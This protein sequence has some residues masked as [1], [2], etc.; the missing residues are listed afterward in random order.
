MKELELRIASYFG[1]QLDLGCVD[2]FWQL[3]ENT[4]SAVHRYRSKRCAKR[5]R[6]KGMREEWEQEQGDSEK[7]FLVPVP[8]RSTWTSSLSSEPHPCANNNS[9]SFKQ[10]S[11]PK[12]TLIKTSLPSHNMQIVSLWV[13]GWKRCFTFCFHSGRLCIPVHPKVISTGSRKQ[14]EKVWGWVRMRAETTSSF[15]PVEIICWS[16]R[17]LTPSCLGLVVLRY[18]FHMSSKACEA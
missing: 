18:R 17:K 3:Y 5:Y 12:R 7:N 6:N 11:G 15:T 2:C 1:V 10:D 14:D 16:L 13:R 9:F 4:K 8:C